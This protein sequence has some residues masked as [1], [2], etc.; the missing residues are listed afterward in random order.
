MRVVVVVVPAVVVVVVPAVAA[1]VVVAVVV[2]AVVP[3]VAVPW[4]L[5]QMCLVTTCRAIQYLFRWDLG[6]VFRS[7]ILK[8]RPTAR[9]FFFFLKKRKIGRFHVDVF[10]KSGT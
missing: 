6:L 7:R 3:V 10:P 1:V 9:V 8:K 2:V 5:A 4:K